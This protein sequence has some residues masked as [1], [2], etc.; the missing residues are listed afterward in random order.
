[1]VDQEF[2]QEHIVVDTSTPR[3]SIMVDRYLDFLISVDQELRNAP[4]QEQ[5]ELLLTLFNSIFLS[6]ADTKSR[7]EYLE[8]AYEHGVRPVIGAMAKHMWHEKDS[9]PAASSAEYE[10]FDSLTEIEN[11]AGA[12]IAHYDDQ[13]ERLNDY[14]LLV[15][16]LKDFV[17]KIRTIENRFFFRAALMLYDALSCIYAEDLTQEQL[18]T[19]YSSVVKLKDLD[20]DKDK[21]Q[22]L[23][24]E[25]RASGFETVPSDRLKVQ[26][27]KR[28]HVDIP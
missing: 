13:D 25:F 18:R 27:K 14:I 15:S 3:Q 22:S 2:E 23:D 10:L 19:V 7:L 5:Q 17:Y 11:I 9:L 12:I 24:K 28:E 4:F 21:L 20:W 6:D 8:T 1:M 16:R 26:E